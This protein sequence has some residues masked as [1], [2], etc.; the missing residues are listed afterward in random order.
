MASPVRRALSLPRLAVAAVGALLLSFVPL[1]PFDWVPSAISENV[2]PHF[3]TAGA[4]E[5]PAATAGETITAARRSTVKTGVEP[6]TAIGLKLG[7]LPTE[8]IFARTHSASGWSTWRDF[9]VTTARG[10][11]GK[12]RVVTEEPIWVKHAD[13][14]EVNVPS[15][16][17]DHTEVVLVRD[18]VHRV[19]S[20]ASPLAGAE[21]PPF[22]VHTRAEW[23]ARPYNGT[24]D[25][26]SSIKLAV[27]H[28]SDSPNTYTPADVPSILR[29]IQAFHMDAN[30]WADIGY[31]FVVDKFGGIWE[32]RAGGM[33]KPVIGAHAKGF[34]TNSV[35]VMVIGD[36]TSAQPSAAA[37]ESVSNVVG[38]KMSLSGNDPSGRVDFT[39]GG[40]DKYA[41]GVVVNLPRVVGHQ[42]VNFTSCPGSIEG[43]LGQIRT[44]AQEWKNWYAAIAKPIGSIDQLSVSGPTVSV[45]GWAIDPGQPTTPIVVDVQ[46][47]GQTATLIADQSRPDVGQVY[48]DAGADH[49]YSG[50]VSGVPPGYQ[51]V[52]VTARNPANG[53][54]ASLG[55][56]DVYL[57]DPT[58]NSPTGLITQ[59]RGLLGGVYVAG[60]VTDPNAP[61][62]ALIVDVEVR[63]KVVATVP[64]DPT[65]GGWWAQP[66]GLP[67][68]PAEVCAVAHNIGP[69]VDIRFSC[70]AVEIAWG[71][72]QG[73]WDGLMGN[74]AGDIGFWGWAWDPET[75]GPIQLQVSVDNRRWMFTADQNR[76]DL[77]AAL[78]PAYGT[79]HGFLGTLHVGTGQHTVCL[80]PLDSP[81]GRLTSFGCL[82][83][84]V[85]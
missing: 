41:A 16:I 22:G 70:T 35:G 67:Y 45:A 64:T 36:Y 85:K 37:L 7:A 59:M 25:Y 71:P 73:H 52:C 61:G 49:G 21:D 6:F 30:G 57:P 82:N 83:T 24:P 66:V 63:G 84:I 4:E 80:S 55:C 27:V 68:G 72:P 76:P 47:A 34:N 20:S 60:K 17:A 51:S 54:S 62:H 50:S 44:R 11:D 69:G 9:D 15:G 53:K 33:D 10:P 56:K 23:G 42:D 38:W 65:T 48:P 12:D 75:T 78:P 26:G 40:A 13:G 5:L 32:A 77:A 58:G 39:S 81:T 8:P 2:V 79:R 46:V 31:N 14:Y 1:L 18:G 3:A 29:S 28:H 43:Y 74:S 19:L